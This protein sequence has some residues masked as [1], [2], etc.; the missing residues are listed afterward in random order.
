MRGGCPGVVH[1]H[2]RAT[3][4]RPR[5]VCG[6]G[7]LCLYTRGGGQ[8][9]A[10]T[11]G[12]GRLFLFSP[13]A[14]GGPAGRDWWQGVQSG[15]GGGPTSAAIAASGSWL[16]CHVLQSDGLLY[17]TMQGVDNLD[18][19]V[20]LTAFEDVLLWEYHDGISN[21]GVWQM[22]A[23]LKENYWFPWMRA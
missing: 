10:T 1:P 18:L 5:G 2:E 3:A 4:A 6:G 22:L 23:H 16:G 8:C 21:L 13:T 20:V 17:C 11:G 14:R 19:L 7:R 12:G 15:T 9:L